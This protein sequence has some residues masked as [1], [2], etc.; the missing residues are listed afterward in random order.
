MQRTSKKIIHSKGQ[1]MC[2][3]ICSTSFIPTKR[4]IIKN[5]WKYSISW[6]TYLSFIINVLQKQKT[7]QYKQVY[8][9]YRC[10]LPY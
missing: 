10:M 2:Q 1:S 3:T 7:T 6:E 8:I 4:K 5:I 9:N